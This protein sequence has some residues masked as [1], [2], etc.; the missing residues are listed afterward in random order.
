MEPMVLVRW[1]LIVTFVVLLVI[2]IKRRTGK[3]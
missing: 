2:V 3:S 1:V